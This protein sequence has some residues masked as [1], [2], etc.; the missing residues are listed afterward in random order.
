MI[1]D[2]DPAAISRVWEFQVRPYLAEYWFEQPDQL[3]Q[4]DAD[5]RALIAEHS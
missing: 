1:D 5:V 2:A 3:A 4:L